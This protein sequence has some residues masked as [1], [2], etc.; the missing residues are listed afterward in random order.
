MWLAPE[1]WMATGLGLSLE[2]A[3][4]SGPRAGACRPAEEPS[5]SRRGRDPPGALAKGTL[6]LIK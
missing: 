4:A 3:A 1:R 2:Q 6:V 5:G